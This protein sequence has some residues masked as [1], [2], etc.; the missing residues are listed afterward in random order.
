MERGGIDEDDEMLL[1]DDDGERPAAFFAKKSGGGSDGKKHLHFAPQARKK[2]LAAVGAEPMNFELSLVD[3]ALGPGSAAIRIATTAGSSVGGD[4]FSVSVKLYPLELE[5]LFSRQPFFFKEKSSNE[6]ADDFLECVKPAWE[7][8]L[9]LCHEDD[10]SRTPGIKIV[11]IPK[12]YVDRELLIEVVEEKQALRKRLLRSAGAALEIQIAQKQGF[13]TAFSK[14]SINVQEESV[15]QQGP[16]QASNSET[17]RKLVPLPAPGAY[18]K[19]Y[20]RYSAGDAKFFKDGYTDLRGRFDYATLSG[21]AGG[22]GS[23]GEKTIKEFAV[24]VV[25]RGAR[26]GG[27]VEVVDA[28]Q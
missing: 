23:S 25:S 12:E 22:G 11:Q 15:A 13:L 18:C 17:R 7:T 9:D 24:L 3:H 14:E 1:V 5:L 27:T 26:G 8:P 19:V 28:P 4:G 2:Q 21:G 16:H 20:A 6:K 10:E